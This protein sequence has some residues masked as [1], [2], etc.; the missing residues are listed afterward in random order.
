MRLDGSKGS[1]RQIAPAA[2]APAMASRRATDG[3][4]CSVLRHAG[5]RDLGLLTTP[6]R[7]AACWGAH[8]VTQ[9]PAFGTADVHYSIG[10]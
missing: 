8:G 6:E 3:L 7:L 9:D 2:K 4:S 10:L 1:T 5:L